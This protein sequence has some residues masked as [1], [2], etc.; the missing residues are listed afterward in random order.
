MTFNEKRRLAVQRELEYLRNL[1]A[2]LRTVGY[3]DYLAGQLDVVAGR[4]EKINAEDQ[5]VDEKVEAL[6]NLL[7]LPLREKSLADM[8]MDELARHFGGA[9]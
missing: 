2:G 7:A 5:A 3:S 4:L 6:D 9:K 1:A 8:T